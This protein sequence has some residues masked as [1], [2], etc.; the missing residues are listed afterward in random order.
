MVQ[1]SHPFFFIILGH[2]N[3]KIM[4]NKNSEKNL[5]GQPIFKQLIDFIPRNK[6]DAL[7]NKYKADRYYKKFSSW[8]QLLTLLFGA[9]SRCDSMGEICDGMMH[10]E[11]AGKTEPPWDVKFTSKEHC[12]RWLAQSK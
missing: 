1:S 8:E 7:V 12:R 3:N 11:Y 9:F 4:S 5:V 2:H 6:F 10:D